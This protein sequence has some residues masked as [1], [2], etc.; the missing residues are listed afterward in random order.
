MNTGP[1]VTTA[2]LLTGA[3]RGGMSLSCKHTQMQAPFERRGVAE[4]G[5]EQ[6][7][8][9]HPDRPRRPQ[10]SRKQKPKPTAEA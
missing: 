5:R 2:I 7:P 8:A 1:D 6:L 3:G 4:A 9:Q 10:K